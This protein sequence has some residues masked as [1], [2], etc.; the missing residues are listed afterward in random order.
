MHFRMAPLVFRVSGPR[1]K[2]GGRE[3]SL[4]APVRKTEAGNSHCRPRV[5]GITPPP[6]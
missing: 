4:A 1:S 6:V 5:C 3:Q 2:D